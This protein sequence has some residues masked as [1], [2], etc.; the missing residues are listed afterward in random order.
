MPECLKTRS[1][2]LSDPG[3]SHKDPRG[4]QGQEGRGEGALLGGRRAREDPGAAGGGAGGAQPS[5]PAAPGPGPRGPSGLSPG[6]RFPRRV[7][8][9]MDAA[10]ALLTS[11]AAWRGRGRGGRGGVLA[12]GSARRRLGRSRSKH[13]NP[14]GRAPAPAPAPSALS[15]DAARRARGLARSWGSRGGVGGE[16]SAGRT[17]RI[18]AAERRGLGL[19]LLRKRQPRGGAARELPRRLPA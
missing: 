13:S 19:R 1:H 16:G 5:L 8:Q 12:S 2:R 4:C 15:P 3:F 7:R 6:R 10:R 14:G 9:G 11:P 17:A 18:S